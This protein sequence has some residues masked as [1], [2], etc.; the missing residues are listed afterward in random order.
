MAV[1]MANQTFAGGSNKDELVR[2]GAVPPLL[3]L[4]QHDNRTVRTHAC[5]VVGIL[6]EQPTARTL[7]RSLN[8]VP[9]IASLLKSEGMLQVTEAMRVGF[10][11]L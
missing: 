4:M 6:S 11:K 1:N 8:C 2:L 9:A 10:A 3:K 5:M 7:L